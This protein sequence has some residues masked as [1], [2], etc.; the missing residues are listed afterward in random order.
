MVHS[1]RPKHVY[2]NPIIVNI[3]LGLVVRQETRVLVTRKKPKDL[4]PRE[5]E[6][7]GCGECGGVYDVWTCE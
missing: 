2:L 3:V 4:S 1:D 7:S 5:R 6:E